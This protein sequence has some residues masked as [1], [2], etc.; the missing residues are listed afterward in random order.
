MPLTQQTLAVA[1]L[2]KEKTLDAHQQSE[3]FLLPYL[4]NI[5]SFDDYAA[6]LKMFY[7]FFHPVE[8]LIKNQVPIEVLPDIA[9]RRN[10]RLILNDLKSIGH[11]N[12]TLL[13][14][15]QPLIDSL[16]RALGVLYVL[17]GSTLGGRMIAKMM[18]KH[19]LFSEDNLNF[20]NGYKEETGKKWTD[21][22][23]VINKFDEEAPI[24]IDAAN[25]TFNL[26]TKWMQQTLNHE[27]KN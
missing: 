26:F 23:A 16:P 22:Q 17:E 15:E 18:M 1:Q 13:S 21:F 9:E 6:I 25:E 5:R 3:N 7:G 12:L 19:P 14:H 4:N 27:S 2:L 10:S 8:Q 11:N 20:F 24:M